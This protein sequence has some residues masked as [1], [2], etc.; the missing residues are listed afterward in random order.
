MRALIATLLLITTVVV[1]GN[2]AA[3][4][5]ALTR[6]ASA[7]PETLA[8]AAPAVAQSRPLAQPALVAAPI[9][10]VPTVVDSAAHDD[11]DESPTARNARALRAANAAD[12]EIAALV[13]DRDPKV[14]SAMRAFF[15]D[16]PSQAAQR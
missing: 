6:V 5:L 15:E 7:L 13:D 3:S 14:R 2:L 9:E 8:H 16:A 10:H 4:Y 1:I 11:E 12:P